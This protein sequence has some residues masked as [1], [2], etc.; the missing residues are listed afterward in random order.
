M[1]PDDFK[2]FTALLDATC[3]MLSRGAYTPNPTS[4]AVFFNTIRQHPLDVVK[5]AFTAHCQDPQRGRFAP[6]PADILAQI[7]GAASKD[8]RPE[9]DEAWAMA[10]P[11]LDE[12]ATVVWT[13]EAAE[14]FGVCRPV[15]D[16]GD[17]VG[18]RMAFKAAYSRLVAAARARREP[19][20]W[21]ASEGHDRGR[22]SAVLIAAV[23]EG[24]LPAAY[25][26]AP[27]VGPVAG[28]LELSRQ[29]G[30][31]DHVRE[32]L[33]EIRHQ[34]TDRVEIESDDAAQKRRTMELKDLVER[35]VSG[36]IKAA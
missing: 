3:M 16:G 11:A 13:A 22:R 18:A 15:L 9:A 34:I 17:E 6:V 2:D 7:E 8:G 21:S 33:L 35:A 12:A 32:R 25:L 5:R 26:P 10:L 24:R 23:E 19:T 4:A 29:R 1:T 14:A 30:C 27:D 28:L 36:R 31:P 20:S